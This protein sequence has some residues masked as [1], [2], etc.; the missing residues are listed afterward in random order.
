M[1]HTKAQGLTAA[2]RW[3]WRRHCCT[4]P[5]ICHELQAAWT[6][7]D[8]RLSA[9]QHSHARCMLCALVTQ[10]TNNQP[11]RAGGHIR[12]CLQQLLLPG[13]GE[14]SGC[15]THTCTYTV[16]WAVH[17]TLLAPVCWLLQARSP[18]D[19][20]EGVLL[21]S[22]AGTELHCAAHQL[23]LGW[24][25]CCQCCAKASMVCSSSSLVQLLQSAGA[26][27]S[28]AQHS[29]GSCCVHIQIDREI[30]AHPMLW[31]C[32]PRPDPPQVAT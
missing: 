25:A 31:R 10:Q 2:P 9:M 16:V 3:T 7:A 22:V 8:A 11:S 23:V 28:R 30:T 14:H 6:D 12:G 20:A 17:N 26:A 1:R 29:Q 5:S 21:N 27:H 13:V 4:K 18:T 15:N 19:A 24:I 32:C